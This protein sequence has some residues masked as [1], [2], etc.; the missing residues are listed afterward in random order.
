ML[1]KEIE[2]A[3]FNMGILEARVRVKVRVK[4]R[5]RVRVR[6]RVTARRLGLGSGTVRFHMGILQAAPDCPPCGTTKPGH[7][8]TS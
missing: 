5:V 3:R 1:R 8:C 7:C 6:V 2:T 4:V